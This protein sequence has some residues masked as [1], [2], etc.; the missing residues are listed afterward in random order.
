LAENFYTYDLKFHS[1][2]GGTNKYRISRNTTDQ[3][4]D[5]FIVNQDGMTFE[6]SSDIPSPENI[7]DGLTRSLNNLRKARLNEGT[8]PSEPAPANLEV[9]NLQVAKIEKFGKAL[10][11]VLISPEE[12][13]VLSTKI[14]T[15]SAAQINTQVR[16]N[17]TDTPELA[18]Y[19]WEALHMSIPDRGKDIQF[20]I[21]PETTISR[22]LAVGP[23]SKPFPDGVK[24]FKVLIVVAEPESL[25]EVGDR[26]EIKS[27]VE[28]LELNA[29]K[30]GQKS[31]FTHK[32]LLAATS[33]KVRDVV[34]DYKPHIIH[35]IGHSLFRN[36][37]GY[38]CLHNPSNPKK[39]VLVEDKKFAK[40]ITASTPFLIV[41]NS[42]EGAQSDTSN[43]YN[44]LAQELIAKGVSYVVA[45]Q[46]VISAKA[47][48]AFSDGFY[49]SLVD[50]DTVAQAVSHGR[51]KIES[52]GHPN[53]IE[54]ITPV[55]YTVENPPLLILAPSD[56]VA[57]AP[58]DNGV[59]DIQLDDSGDQNED[60]DRIAVAVAAGAAAGAAA[61]TV[62]ATVL[63]AGTVEMPPSNVSQSAGQKFLDKLIDKSID[64][65]IGAAALFLAGVFGTNKLGG[66]DAID[67][68]DYIIP[69]FLAIVAIGAFYLGWLAN[70]DR[71]SRRHRDEVPAVD[72]PA[73]N[74]TAPASPSSPTANPRTSNSQFGWRWL[75]WL[76]PLLLLLFASLFSIK[77]CKPSLS[78]D[79]APIV[80]CWDGSE[81]E[82]QNACPKK[83]TCWDGS[84]ATTV[85]ACPTEPP[86]TFTCPD[87]NEVTDL[88]SCPVTPIPSPWPKPEVE[89]V[90]R[91]SLTPITQSGEHIIAECSG[92]L[93]DEE[94]ANCQ[95]IISE[96]QQKLK[97]QGYYSGAIDGRY[98]VASHQ[99]YLDFAR[100]Q[101]VSTNRLTQDSLVALG[102]DWRFPLVENQIPLYTCWDGSIVE[103]LNDCQQQLSP[104][105]ENMVT[106]WNSSLAENFE[107]CPAQASEPAKIDQQDFNI[108]ISDRDA[109]PLVRIPPVIPHEA[110]V[111]GH[112]DLIFDISEEGKPYNIKASYCTSD[113]FACPA[114]DT[115]K[116]WKFTP[117]IIDGLA[118]KRN[119]VF[120]NVKFIVKN[121]SGNPIPAQ[122][123]NPINDFRTE[124]C[125][126]DD[127]ADSDGAPYFAAKIGVIENGTGSSNV[128]IDASASI[129][130][131]VG[132]DFAGPFRTEVSYHRRSADL[133]FSNIN[134]DWLLSTNI[135]SEAVLLTSYYQFDTDW[136]FSP[137]LKA[138]IGL[139]SNSTDAVV[140]PQANIIE[141]P[142]QSTDNFSWLLGAGVEIP[143]GSDWKI[144]LEYNYFDTGK[145][146][147]EEATL[148]E[149]IENRN[150]TGHEVTMGFRYTFK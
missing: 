37:K 129:H 6:L 41:L 110:S 85:L 144:D 126:V 71:A 52:L 4:S 22:I 61:G 95:K 132:Y 118:V 92:I 11:S 145:I 80:T 93:S 150:L 102:I 70:R 78:L 89:P 98:G 39:H 29:F 60:S 3:N 131:V 40:Q 59:A 8:E 136:D 72:S 100:S 99:A 48:N 109:Q 130:L 35:Y 74:G 73:G 96:I 42:C 13:G 30:A 46:H 10:F 7:K 88:T 116:K 143:L 68:R 54:F 23:R 76:L 34:K 101:G 84:L 15:W 138:G 90:L 69:S 114:I 62:A 107:L 119:G 16:I 77:S 56:V 137:F 139:S 18:K 123:L 5:L 140:N 147:E 120:Q 65:I 57:D 9:L 94:A 44:G 115:A 53:D 25:G 111:S 26:A 104:P 43:P 12:R 122:E 127:T 146:L 63:N 49:Q 75:K 124:Q 55:L 2:A 148:L 14:D 133:D 1:H 106:C 121:D 128:N 28:H 50:N 81:A 31:L 51:A 64:K 82:N 79:S 83:V 103:D 17:L 24:Q 38:I 20:A 47:A 36:S 91:P 87:G 113:I 67:V 32:L 58:V 142:E 86:A 33:A 141:V 134:P 27:I 135:K 66:N 117:K 19:A 108:R 149:V 21:E 125:L 45:M 97:E 105:P 112:C